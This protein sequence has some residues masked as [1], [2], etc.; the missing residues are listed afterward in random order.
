MIFFNVCYDYLTKLHNGIGYVYSR[1]NTI[2][3]TIL[4]YKLCVVIRVESGEKIPE[5]L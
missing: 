1:K 4:N 2:P 5:G 3:T